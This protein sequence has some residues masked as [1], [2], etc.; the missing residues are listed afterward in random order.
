MD[1]G[2]SSRLNFAL[3]LKRYIFGGHT[4]KDG[5][6]LKTGAVKE[7]QAVARFHTQ[8]VFD[9]V[10]LRSLDQHQ[11]AGCRRRINKKISHVLSV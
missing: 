6:I 11:G 4:D 3:N 8:H 9:V 1:T 7:F 5:L 2:L 10:S